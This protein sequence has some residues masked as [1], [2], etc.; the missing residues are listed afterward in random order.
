MI[1]NITVLLLFFLFS[2]FPRLV[3]GQQQPLFTQY[4]FNGLVINPAYAGVGDAFS[5]STLARWQWTGIEGAPFTATLSAHSPL[6]GDKVSLGLTL[7][8]DEVAVTSQTGIYGAY[9]YKL[10]IGDGYLSMGLQAGFTNFQANY[11]DVYTVNP[12][13]V[14][15]EQV[16]KFIPNVGAGLFYYN[17]VFYVGLSSPFLIQNNVKNG[18]INIYSQKNHYFLS[19]GM[20]FNLLP[21]IQ[22]KPNILVKLVEG[23]PLSVDY[24]V[25]FLF[26]ELFWV[27]ISYRP[28][29][30]V[31][32]LAEV[33]IFDRLR[34]GYAYDYIID[35][36][37]NNV[38]GSS[39]E[40]MLNY[41]INLNKNRVVTPRCRCF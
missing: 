41:R 18:D 24:N 39:H 1:K 6:R 30:S 14:F 40:I 26:E 38:A 27:G 16:T 13:V 7:I 34:L 37:L 25:N 31:S 3:K 12:D 32:F 4:M 2:L 20:V 9:S 10:P 33:K 22:A 17:S 35:E 28:P 5:I 36:T 15:Q 21:D 8:R 19:S 29:E 11:Q 23:S